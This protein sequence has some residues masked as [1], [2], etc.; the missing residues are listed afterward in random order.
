MR[1]LLLPLAL[2]SALATP[3][4]A[5]AFTFAE[6]DTPELSA[7]TAI[8]ALDGTLFSTFAGTHQIGQ[9]TFGGVQAAPIDVAGG[10]TPG[11]LTVG[12]DNRLWFADDGT[13]KVGRYVPGQATAT[14]PVSL[15]GDPADI[16]PG[17]AGTVWVAEP[18]AGQVEGV[19]TVNLVA[20]PYD[21]GLAHPSRIALGG[22]GALWLLDTG[23]GA[24]LRLQPGATCAIPPARG[25]P[26][27]VPPG[28]VGTTDTA[29]A[30]PGGPPRG[31]AGR[32][33]R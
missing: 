25:A 28:G 27:G 30:G 3:A 16:A 13:D 22:D 20:T 6:W 33:P 18:A 23:A 4:T 9:A 17:P 10:E 12:P 11:P 2:A 24:I 31:G 15:A 26:A 32:Q 19:S 7:P 14:E 29:P 21:S 8:V 5:S 1:R